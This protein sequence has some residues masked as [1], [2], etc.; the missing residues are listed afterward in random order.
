MHWSRRGLTNLK[1]AVTISIGLCH[2]FMQHNPNWPTLLKILLEI[3]TNA[4]KDKCIHRSLVF[5]GSCINSW[6]FLFCTSTHFSHFSKV[7]CSSDS[8]VLITLLP[9]SSYKIVQMMETEHFKIWI[10]LFPQNIL[11][12]EH[13][14][15]NNISSIFQLFLSED[16]YISYTLSMYICFK[17]NFHAD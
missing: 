6:V 11:S 3:G 5:K 12:N 10:A 14:F 2:S 15:Y 4:V 16:Y 13:V 9:W 7:E 8:N 1:T 17:T